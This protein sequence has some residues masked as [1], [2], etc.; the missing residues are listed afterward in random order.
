MKKHSLRYDVPIPNEERI[1]ETIRLGKEILKNKKIRGIDMKVPCDIILDLLPLYQNNL[2][3]EV[4]GEYITEH[5]TTCDNCYHILNEMEAVIDIPQYEVDDAIAK[6]LHPVETARN[7]Q[8]NFIASAS[9]E[10]RSPLAAIQSY[11]ET[12]VAGPKRDAILQECNRMTGL[13]QSMLS[14]AACDAGMWQMDFQEADVDMLLFETWETFSEK[15]RKKDIRLNLD[16][17]ESYPPIC[18]DKGKIAQALGILLD[19][20]ISYSPSNTSIELGAKVQA[21]QL[22][23]SVTDHGQGIPDSEKE[24]VFQRFYSG[25]PSRTDKSHYGLGL[26]IAQE[27]VKQHCGTI[28]LKDTINGGCSFELILPLLT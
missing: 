4:T 27:I 25:D 17:E 5:L 14:L 19:N 8:N 3:S 20:A 13:I 7:S 1:Q 18:C 2:C 9:H 11:A 22:V 12:M 10:L 26:S 23:L 24:K 16:V 6:A 28:Y 15:A 21:K